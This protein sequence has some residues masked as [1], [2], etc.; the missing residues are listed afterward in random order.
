MK[1]VF[2]MLLSI[3]SKPRPVISKFATTMIAVLFILFLIN[4]RYNPY[5][6]LIALL[7][8]S[9]AV[10]MVNYDFFDMPHARANISSSCNEQPCNQLK[11]FAENHEKWLA[12][13]LMNCKNKKEIDF[14]YGLLKFIN[15]YKYYRQE[16]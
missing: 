12:D 10:A 15:K 3:I 8:V 7:L 6:L 14:Y 13:K 5:I 1:R 4:G 16:K 11:D 2:A 9:V